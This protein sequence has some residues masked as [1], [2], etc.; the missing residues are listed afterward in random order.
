MSFP[1]SSTD[2]VLNISSGLLNLSSTSLIPESIDRDCLENAK[3]LL[4][5]DKKFIPVIAS[6]TLVILDQV[7]FTALF[8]LFGCY[9]AQSYKCQCLLY[10]FVKTICSMPP[11]KG[12][13]WKTCIER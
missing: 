2:D 13:A 3:V 5:L 7:L 1:H 12:F 11:M 4:Q 9:L 6:D 8:V 10:S